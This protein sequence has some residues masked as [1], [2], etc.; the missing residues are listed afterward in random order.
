MEK[1]NIIKKK[2]RRRNI[3]EGGMRCNSREEMIKERIVKEK[4]SRE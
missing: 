3:N 4:K 1:E 2:E